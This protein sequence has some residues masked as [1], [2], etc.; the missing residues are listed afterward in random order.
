MTRNDFRQLT[1]IECAAI[2]VRAQQEAEARGLTDLSPSGLARALGVSRSQ[3]YAR[4]AA[5]G[6]DLP[7]KSPGRPKKDPAEPE[8]QQVHIV[9]AAVRDFLMDNPGAVYKRTTRYVYADEFR[10]F[11]LDVLSPG[12]LGEGLTAAQAS[13]AT[14]VPVHTI[15]SWRTNG[16]RR[17]KKMADKPPKAP[18]TLDDSTPVFSPEVQRLITLFEA[19]KGTFS[20]FCDALP[21]HGIHLSAEKVAQILDLADVR[22]RP[23]RKRVEV[24]AEMLRGRL[25]RFFANAQLCEDGKNVSITLGDKKY[26]FSWQVMVDVATNAVVGFDVRT[27]ESGDGFINALD[28]ATETAKEPPLAT[29][30]DRRKCNVSQDVEDALEKQGIESILTPKKRPQT[31]APAENL[32]SLVSQTMPGI[33]IDAENPQQLAKSLLEYILLA[34]VLGRNLVPRK[35]LN[36]KTP[37]DAFRERE[38]DDEERR[39]A[40]EKLKKRAR[41]SRKERKRGGSRKEDPVVKALLHTEFQELDIE[42]S[43]GKTAAFLAKLGMDVALEAIALYRA[44]IEGGFEPNGSRAGYLT[45]IAVRLANRNEDM[46]QYHHHLRLRMKAGELLFEPFENQLAAL[47]QELEGKELVRSLVRRS[48]AASTKA[49]RQFWWRAALTDF[50]ALP[51]DKR[52]NTGDWMANRTANRRSIHLFEKDWMIAQVAKVA[53]GYPM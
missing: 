43:K 29:M 24:D 26:T 22:P 19:W 37:G 40:Q 15:N 16:R 47:R 41:D 34:F 42:D 9:M 35:R 20:G 45:G 18:L 33:N 23:R 12:G 53:S 36:G 7:H 50:A 32:F 1:E 52:R 49:E 13:H 25:E 6:D 5:L 14:G 11:V 48:H 46:R 17:T 8:P 30:R 44:R 28:Q 2:I 4:A 31:N 3:I 38:V 39:K 21:G 10:A 27:A 51:V